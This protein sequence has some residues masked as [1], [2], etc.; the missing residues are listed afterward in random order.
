MIKIIFSKHARNKIL[1]RKIKE[2]FLK[3]TIIN[4]DSIYYDVFSK[5]F[6]AIKEVKL[7]FSKVKSNL[8]VSF[9]KEKDVIKII[10]VYPCRKIDK[11]IRKKGAKRWVKVK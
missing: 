3:E 2:P 9:T 8:V 6:I 4:P 1:E 5:T 7:V 10:T 11:E